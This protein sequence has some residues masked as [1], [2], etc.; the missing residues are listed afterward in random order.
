MIVD[1]WYINFCISVS[2]LQSQTCGL[3]RQCS[4]SR[5]W[6]LPDPTLDTSLRMES[7]MSLSGPRLS[8]RLQNSHLHIE[9]NGGLKA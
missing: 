1:Y 6:R 2:L 7:R 9:N 4:L 8:L 5:H 3:Y